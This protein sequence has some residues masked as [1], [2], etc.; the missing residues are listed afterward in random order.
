VAAILS[1]S[2]EALR[3]KLERHARKAPDGVVEAEID[4][5]RGRKFGRSWRVL[6]SERW[7]GELGKRPA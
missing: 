4:G 2:D 5:I 6:L 7:L 3:K 1:M